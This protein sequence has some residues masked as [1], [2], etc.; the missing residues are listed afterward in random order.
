MIS[1][2]W[3]VPQGHAVSQGVTL[4]YGTVMFHFGTFPHTDQKNTTCPIRL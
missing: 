4:E 3:A 1:D 2:H